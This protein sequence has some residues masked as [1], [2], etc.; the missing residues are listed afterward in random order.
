DKAEGKLFEHADIEQSILRA[1]EHFRAR[2]LRAAIM[3]KAKPSV[4]SAATTAFPISNFSE[5]LERLPT[6]C[7]SR[8]APPVDASPQ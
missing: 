7:W 5:A 4:G 6:E 1:A 2:G 8:R 3:A